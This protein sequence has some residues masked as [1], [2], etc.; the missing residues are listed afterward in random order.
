M[1]ICWSAEMFNTET[2]FQSIPRLMLLIDFLEMSVH[3]RFGNPSKS[4]DICSFA[5]PWPRQAWRREIRGGGALLSEFPGL[6]ASPR[7]LCFRSPSDSLLWTAQHHLSFPFLHPD[8]SYFTFLPPRDWLSDSR[9]FQSF[10]LTRPETS[11]DVGSVRVRLSL[12]E[13]FL[14]AVIL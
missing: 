5:P 11:R 9:Y 12:R 13:L 10:T 6:R 8:Q 7:Q 1:S 2:C 3:L 4:V 14:G